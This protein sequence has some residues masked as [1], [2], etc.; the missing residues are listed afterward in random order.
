[1]GTPISSDQYLDTMIAQA[2]QSFKD[3]RFAFRDDDGGRWCIAK[4]DAEGG[5]TGIMAAEIISTRFGALYVGADIDCCVFSH[6]NETNH[7]D[8]QQNHVAKLRWI[9]CNKSVSYYVRQKAMA[10][11]SDG[12]KLV[13][14]YNADVARYDLQ[15]LIDTYTHDDP[16]SKLLGPLKE[17]LSEW[18]DEG[19]SMKQFLYDSGF[20]SEELPEIGRVL[21]PRVVYAWAACKRACELID[22]KGERR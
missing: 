15:Q 20:E 16:E 22:G 17:A 3:H 9:G 10:G 12:G 18:I 11:L 8:N 2:I 1:M 21:R 6:Y 14:G 5:F 13:D 4:P 19:E 7:I